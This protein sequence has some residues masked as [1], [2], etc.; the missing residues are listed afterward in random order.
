[1]NN[2]RTILKLPSLVSLVLVLP[3]LVMELIN[4][5]SYNEDFPLAIFVFLWLLSFGFILLLK[6]IASSKGIRSIV[7]FN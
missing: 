3:F 6:P 4:R 5:E 1:M 7:M 2:I